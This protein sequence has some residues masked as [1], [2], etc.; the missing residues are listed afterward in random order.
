MKY[1][2]PP[3]RDTP[4]MPE[5]VTFA[6]AIVTTRACRR[7]RSELRDRGQVS[8]I[9]A[10]HLGSGKVIIIGPDAGVEG[11]ERSNVAHPQINLRDSKSATST[12]SEN[13]RSDIAVA[14]RE[15]TPVIVPRGSSHIGFPEVLNPGKQRGCLP[16]QTLV[17][18][19]RAIARKQS[20]RA[21][22]LFSGC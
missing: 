1:D 12:Y 8:P 14:S 18:R 21:R 4:E 10:G 17:L 11:V 7:A 3:V 13:A 16:L 2:W 9:G 19:H 15:T 20:A 6:A 22:F 5:T